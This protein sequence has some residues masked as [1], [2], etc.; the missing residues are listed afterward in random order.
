MA[1]ASEGPDE[2]YL[3]DCG[4][5]VWEVSLLVDPPK[6]EQQLSLREHESLM[7]MAERARVDGQAYRA[8]TLAEQAYT[9]RRVVSSL[10]YA[11]DIRVNELGEP[12]FGAAAFHSMLRMLALG[13][14]ERYDC[15]RAHERAA[16]LMEAEREQGDAARLIQRA[17]EV[18]RSSPLRTGGASAFSSSPPPSRLAPSRIAPSSAATT[19]AALGD[20]S[21]R[22]TRGKGSFGGLGWGRD[23][24]YDGHNESESKPPPHRIAKGLTTVPE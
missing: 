10:L 13:T 11:L 15:E 24:E 1:T 7:S 12:A 3:E 22:R 19:A 5:P 16:K 23:D 18:R 14:R 20:S 9:G 21:P 4:I 17:A 8:Y 6:P 2:R